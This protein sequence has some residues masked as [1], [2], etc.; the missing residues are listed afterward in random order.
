MFMDEY[1]KIN[2]PFKRGLD[3]KLIPGDWARPEFGYLANNAWIWTEKVD[4]MNIR[5]G[6]DGERVHFAGRTNKAHI[7]GPLLTVL[8]ELFPAEKFALFDSEVT[9]Y[10]EGY[11][12]KIQSGGGYRNDPGFVLFDVNIGG[13]WLDHFNV[14]DVATKLDIEVTH[15]WCVDTLDAAISIVAEGM[16]SVVARRNGKARDA[17]GL[18]GVPAVSLFNRMGERIITKVKVKDFKNA[19]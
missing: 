14:S 16:T 11:G 7:P 1:P 17:E 19:T 2:A 5:V 15:L 10:G 12:A 6:W 9:L 13:W 3:K 8:R 4:G 18:V